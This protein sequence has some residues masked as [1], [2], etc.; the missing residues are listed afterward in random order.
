MSPAFENEAIRQAQER[1][2]QA[3]AYRANCEV[4]LASAQIKLQAA[5]SAFDEKGAEVAALEVM[6][7]K[8]MLE[9]APLPDDS[10]NAAIRTECQAL[11]SLYSTTISRKRPPYNPPQAESARANLMV[12]ADTLRAVSQEWGQN[13]SDQR[14]TD[15][16]MRC[17]NM[18]LQRIN[19]YE[20]VI[21]TARSVYD[22]EQA[23]RETLEPVQVRGRRFV[24]GVTVPKYA[25][26]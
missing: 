23:Q 8:V 1:Q 13:P 2:T 15:R 6:Q 16:L 26:R 5:A 11:L 21:N 18:L 22:E 25:D 3:N 4:A 24:R 12:E 20:A 10:L 9:A 19:E 17:G 7:A 14:L